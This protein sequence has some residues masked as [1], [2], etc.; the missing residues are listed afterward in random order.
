MSKPKTV[1]E[2]V[3][4]MW[5]EGAGFEAAYLNNVL[6]YN[7]V[8][9][10]R[11]SGLWDALVGAQGRVV[12]TAEDVD[13]AVEAFELVPDGTLASDAVKALLTAAGGVVADEVVTVWMDGGVY[14]GDDSEHPF[15]NLDER[16]ALFIVRRPF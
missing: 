2:L 7:T 5:P 12:Y 13:R 4:S 14:T 6:V 11:E 10:L 15:T 8:N 3:E 9:A 1:G 16:D